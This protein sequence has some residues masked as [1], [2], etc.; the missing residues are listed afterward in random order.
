MMTALNRT[1]SGSDTFAHMG[2]AL[3]D[4]ALQPMLLRLGMAVS[5]INSRDID[6]VAYVRNLAATII[7]RRRVM[8]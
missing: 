4:P 1:R 5:D 2:S 6:R 8:A 3:D 7:D